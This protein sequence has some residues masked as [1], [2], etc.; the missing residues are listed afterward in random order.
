MFAPIVNLR[1]G[2]QHTHF[3]I[4]GLGFGVR[5]LGSGSQSLLSCTDLGDLGQ[6][7]QIPQLSNGSIVPTSRVFRRI[8]VI[9]CYSNRDY[10]NFTSC[11]SFFLDPHNQ[12]LLISGT[13]GRTLLH[14]ILP[15]LRWPDGRS[16]DCH[17]VALP[18]SRGRE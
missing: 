6:A 2:Q 1:K 7:T 8:R 11:Q 14:F 18:S 12:G 13:L 16:Y 15:T 3:L 5:A 9:P 4:G 10:S 17:W